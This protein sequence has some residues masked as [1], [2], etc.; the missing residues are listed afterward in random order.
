M[1]NAK[2]YGSV[3]LFCLVQ[4]SCLSVYAQ[5]SAVIGDR[6][7]ASVVAPPGGGGISGY[8]SIQSFFEG[9]KGKKVTLRGVL[10][11]NGHPGGVR[12]ADGAYDITV[13][14]NA[15]GNAA[16]VE[17][18]GLGYRCMDLSLY[19]GSGG[20]FSAFSDGYNY[21]VGGIKGT[22]FSSL[23]ASDN[24]SQSFRIWGD[25]PNHAS[26]GGYFGLGDV[27]RWTGSRDYNYFHVSIQYSPFAGMLV[28]LNGG[29]CD[30]VQEEVVRSPGIGDIANAT[31][32]GGFGNGSMV[33]DGYDG[34]VAYSVDYGATDAEFL[35]KYEGS[36]VVDCYKGDPAAPRSYRAGLPDC[37]Y[38]NIG[39]VERLWGNSATRAVF[40]NGGSKIEER[41]ISG[42]RYSRF[43]GPTPIYATK[44]VYPV[45]Y[46]MYRSRRIDSNTIA[47][48][49]KPG[50]CNQVQN[51]PVHFKRTVSVRV[52]VFG[53][54]PSSFVKVGAER[55]KYPEFYGSML[56]ALKFEVYI[57]EIKIPDIEGLDAPTNLEVEKINLE[58]LELQKQWES[59]LSFSG[60]RA[61]TGVLTPRATEW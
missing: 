50:M 11:G 52:P 14:Y 33:S 22:H 3:G 57:P 40:F 46:A 17:V 43:G 42:Y 49:Q 2:W 56:E 59:A 47:V 35:K 41:Y 7:V 51:D 60:Y 27:L 6:A 37:W 19:T 24:I 21:E 58:Q 15:S 31:L 23:G 30:P 25:K 18:H 28:D 38:S 9:V 54:V 20:G 10:I 61:W 12:G 4:L 26:F 29:F 53:S 55:K 16:C 39:W 34:E 32:I 48:M 13:G 1:K 45:R 36:G 8:P 5:A 44:T